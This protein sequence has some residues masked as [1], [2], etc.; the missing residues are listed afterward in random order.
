VATFRDIPASGLPL[1]LHSLWIQ[2]IISHI[3]LTF[4]WETLRAQ[5]RKWPESF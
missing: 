4:Y 2:F 5:N 1:P 3:R